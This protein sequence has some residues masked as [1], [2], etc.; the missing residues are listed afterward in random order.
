MTHPR[1]VNDKKPRCRAALYTHYAET[2]VAG[3]F[4]R[5]QSPFYFM[6]YARRA[7]TFA[8]VTRAKSIL[9]SL[10]SRPRTHSAVESEN[11]NENM[12]F[13]TRPSKRVTRVPFHISLSQTQKPNVRIWISRPLVLTY[14]TTSPEIRSRLFERFP[15]IRSTYISFT[16]YE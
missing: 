2:P 15:Q 14:A 5:H 9:F 11:F 12:S 7:I 1:C 16:W 3:F 8:P 10:R 4:D 13:H 6:T